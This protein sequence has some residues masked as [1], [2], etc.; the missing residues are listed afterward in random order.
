MHPIEVLMNE[1]RAIEAV[2]DTLV[3]FSDRL[4]R[5]DVLPDA[6]LPG[7]AS[8]I[9]DYA[10]TLHHGKEEDILFEAM[11]NAGMPTDGGPLAV[12]LQHHEEGRRLVGVL[13]EAREAW[14]DGERKRVAR[15]AKDY[16][17][18]LRAHIRI[19]DEVLY[20]MARARVPGSAWDSMTRDFEVFENSHAEEKARLNALA[21]DL[22]ARHSS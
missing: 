11:A 20:P 2:I 16:A 6:D 4:E 22:A 10:D 3:A 21:K 9:R 15:A 1:H 14:T 18:L 8:W 13:S 7:L 12:M 5:G 19:E 17:D